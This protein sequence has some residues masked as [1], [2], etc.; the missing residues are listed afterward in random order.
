MRRT[1]ALAAFAVTA[2]IVSIFTPS[3]TS[4]QSKDKAKAAPKAP[5]LPTNVAAHR[6][7]AYGE[8]GE[9]N[10]LD[11]YLPK[12]E[13]PLPLLIWI[14]GGGWQ[15]GSKAGGG[16]GMFLLER[17]YAVASINYRLS[18]QATFPAQI[19]D[20]KAAIR[21]LRA[22]AKKHNLDADHF[23]VWG[24]SAGG[25]LVAL[26]GTSGDVTDL[27]GDGA[28]KNVSSRVQAVCDFFGP[29]DF[30][31]MNKQTVVKGPIDHDSPMSPEAKL[32]G[33]AVQENKSKAAKANPLTYATSDDAPVLIV[34]GDKDPLVPLAQ[35]EILVESLKAVKVPCELV[36][37]KDAGHGGPG[38]SSPEMREKIQGFFDKNLKVKK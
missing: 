15:A 30:T 1:L 11:L 14:H 12:S 20:C 38:F 3:F 33:G 19:E 29:T 23:G 21:F 16:P 35:S 18:S 8:R 4:A 25:H 37:I 22:N 28:N 34:H 27:E 24:S 26:L 36:V 31:L 17:G 9:R 13:S 2:G 6:D 32:I 7:L 10:T 5:P